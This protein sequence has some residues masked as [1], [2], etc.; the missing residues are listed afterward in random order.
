MHVVATRM[1]RFKA[2]SNILGSELIVAFEASIIHLFTF[3]TLS[4][5]LADKLVFV[6]KLMN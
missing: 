2:S 1:L 4:I 3:G 6:M 5:R